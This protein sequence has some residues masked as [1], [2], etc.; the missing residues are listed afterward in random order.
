MT[1]ICNV[2]LKENAPFKCSVCKNVFYCSS[3]HQNQ[4]WPSH[5]KGECNPGQIEQ[6]YE[7]RDRE[8]TAT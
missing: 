2:C 4:D 3:A 5:K 7:Y 1:K 6:T 8:K